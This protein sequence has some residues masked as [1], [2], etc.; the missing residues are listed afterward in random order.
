MYLNVTFISLFLK[1]LMKQVQYSP[2]KRMG[3]LEQ[4]FK[5][6]TLSVCRKKDHFGHFKKKY[7]KNFLAIGGLPI[8]SFYCDMQSVLT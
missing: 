3:H 6:I 7:K 5:S 8:F 2:R 4:E 1:V